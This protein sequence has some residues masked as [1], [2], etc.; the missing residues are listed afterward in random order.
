VAS[1]VTYDAGRDSTSRSSITSGDRNVTF[2]RTGPALNWYSVL[3]ARTATAVCS[4]ASR[5]TSAPP[6]NR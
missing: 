2:S 4:A 3:V 5:T 1:N 6:M